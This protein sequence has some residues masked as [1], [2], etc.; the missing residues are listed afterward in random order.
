M[1][2][3]ARLYFFFSFKENRVLFLAELKVI[4]E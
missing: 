3:F 4:G 2:K 1:N